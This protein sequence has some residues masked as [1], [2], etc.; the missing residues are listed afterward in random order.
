MQQERCVLLH[1][2]SVF[3]LSVVFVDLMYF[4]GLFFFYKFV[5]CYLLLY[6]LFLLL[7][8]MFWCSF[9]LNYFLFSCLLFFVFVFFFFLYKIRKQNNN[10]NMQL[11]TLPPLNS[12]FAAAAVTITTKMATN[13]NTRIHENDGMVFFSFFVL[14][15]VL[16]KFYFALK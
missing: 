16:V 9:F 2:H 15:S 6:P 11:W 7:T 8:T 12:A 13:Q 5:V 14:L 3:W 4:S 1:F 10:M